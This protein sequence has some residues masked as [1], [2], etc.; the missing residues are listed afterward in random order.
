[1][2]TGIDGFTLLALATADGA[3]PALRGVA[4]LET[5]RQVWVQNFLVKHGPEGSRVG[6]RANDQA[7]PSGRYIGSPYDTEARYATKDARCGAA[8]R[9]T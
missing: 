4:A 3:P 9:R 1:M 2:R 8:T 6:W 7:P 5:L